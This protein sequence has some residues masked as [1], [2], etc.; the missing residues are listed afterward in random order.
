MYLPLEFK[1]LRRTLENSNSE[2]LFTA[3]DVSAE[4]GSWMEPPGRETVRNPREGK[5]SGSP[6]KGNS[7]FL[8]F[9]SHHGGS[10][11]P[12]RSL[13]QRVPGGVHTQRD[14]S[15]TELLTSF[16]PGSEEPPSDCGMKGTLKLQGADGHWTPRKPCQ[17]RGTPWTSSPALP[18]AVSCLCCG[19]P[20]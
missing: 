15:D 16:C 12:R 9:P 10:K 8:S 18:M 20:Q 11:G 7:L 6:G 13:G 14:S 3:I 17:E 4:R 5:L 19:P 1:L 2:Y